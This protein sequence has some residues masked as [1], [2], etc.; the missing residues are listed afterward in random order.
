MSVILT[1]PPALCTTRAFFQGL[2]IET[3]SCLTRIPANNLRFLV[4]GMP[5]DFA[6][7]VWSIGCTLYELYT[8]KILFTGRT[9]NQMLRSIMEC[10]GKFSHKFLRKGQF[11]NLHFDDMLNF[12]S[13]EKDKITGRVGKSPPPTTF[14]LLLENLGI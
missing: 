8:G 3:Y 13:V 4:L 1:P 2:Y 10:R 7:D 11:T 6:I 14:L 5:Y 9:N 12:R